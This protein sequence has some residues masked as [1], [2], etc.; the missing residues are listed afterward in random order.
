M[1]NISSSYSV[2]RLRPGSISGRQLTEFQTNRGNGRFNFASLKPTTLEQYGWR[3]DGQLPQG[4]PTEQDYTLDGLASAEQSTAYVADDWR[5][6]SKLTVNLGLRYEL[7]TPYSEVSDRWA[8]FDPAT[9]T[10]LVAGRNGVS[11]YAGVET[12][13]KGFAPRFGFGT[14]WR[15]RRCAAGSESSTTLPV[16]EVPFFVCSGMFPSG[17]ST[18]SARNFIVSRRVSA[19]S[20]RSGQW[21][22]SADNLAAASLAYSQTTSQAMRNS[23]TDAGTRDCSM[24]LFQ[25]SY[26]ANLGRR[27]IPRLT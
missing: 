19:V 21:L 22:A 2:T 9:A 27:L 7:D 10:V 12:W 25:G 3:R 17:L 13:K 20:Q 14:P 26:V 23:S 8:N 5:A 18:A 4:A 6:S 11:K 24:G 15:V 16:T 1:G